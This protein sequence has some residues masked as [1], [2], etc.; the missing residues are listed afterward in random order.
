[1][2]DREVWCA[3]VNGVAKSW[4]WLSDWTELNWQYEPCVSKVMFLLLIHQ[5]IAILPGKQASFNFVAIPIVF[6]WLRSEFNTLMSVFIYLWQYIQQ[7]GSISRELCWVK[8][9]SI[10][11]L[12]YSFIC[13][14]FWSTN[15]RNGEQS[16]DFQGLSWGCAEIVWEG[17]GCTYKRAV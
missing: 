10:P 14:I 9:T 16:R 4:T 2:M 6:H 5:V 8:K 1:M 7:P 15:I 17:S 3:V 13:I 11:I 12:L